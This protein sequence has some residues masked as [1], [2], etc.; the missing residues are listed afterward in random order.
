MPLNY[1]EFLIGIDFEQLNNF[2]CF[3]S[4]EYKGEIEIVADNLSFHQKSLYLRGICATM[5]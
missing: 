5:T 3:V 4:E 2:L 1:F